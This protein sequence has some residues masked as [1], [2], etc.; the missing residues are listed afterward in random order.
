MIYT[1]CLYD[2][3]CFKWCLVRYLHSADHYPTRIRKVDKDLA[4]EFGFKY[5][6]FPVKIRDI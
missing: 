2:N 5:I 6:N 1:I 3:E 4:R